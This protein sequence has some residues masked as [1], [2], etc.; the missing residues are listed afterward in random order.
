ML[1]RV[2]Y[3]EDKLSDIAIDV[4]ILKDKAAT[5][6]DIGNVKVDLHKDLNAQT[7]KIISALFIAVL[8]AVLSHYFIK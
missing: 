3:L 5:K 8:L 2:K 4:A 6:E 1:Q 7:R